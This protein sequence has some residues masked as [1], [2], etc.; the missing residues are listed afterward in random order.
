M[1]DERIR[2]REHATFEVAAEKFFVDGKLQLYEETQSRN[3]FQIRAKGTNLVFQAG[4]FIGLIPVNDNVTIEV[5]PRS[6]ISNLSRILR[7]AGADSD[8]IT[9]ISR[10]YGETDEDLS[11]V[12]VLADELISALE[13]VAMDG[14]VKTYE[15][16]RHF[17]TP[18]SGRVLIAETLRARAANPGGART[19]SS[20]FERTANN[21]A[22]AAIKRAVEKLAA[23]IQRGRPRKGWRTRLRGLNEAWQ[24]FA[25]VDERLA[26][27]A[28]L[29]RLRRSQLNQ[30]AESHRRALAVAI[31]VL[32]DRSPAVMASDGPLSLASVVYNL[33]TAFECYVRN[34]LSQAPSLNVRDGNL[35]PPA[36]AASKLFSQP[37]TPGLA[38]MVANPDLVLG[39]KNGLVA[40]ADIKYK[41]FG[42]APDREDLN[43]ALTYGVAYDVKK[44]ILV[45]PAGGQLKGLVFCGLVGDKRV[46]CYGIDIGAAD[47]VAEEAAM[48]TAFNA[49]VTNNI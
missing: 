10:S 37:A 47:L 5:T 44:C 17:G 30:G 15:N 45:Y 11:L 6:P 9:R 20:Q 21:T 36:G 43:Q 12:D 2:V 8:V 40:A 46:Y 3:Y 42:A 29:E 38:Q 27:W 35:S 13:Q 16:K 4:G 1:S 32:S 24:M 19:V 22:N 25:R 7:I 39:P 18:R 33:S 14:R 26:G 34:V 31:A 48:V 23:D 28:E 49:I 41:L